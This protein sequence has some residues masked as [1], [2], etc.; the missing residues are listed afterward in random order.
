MLGSENVLRDV[1]GGWWVALV[2][3]LIGWSRVKRR[4]ATHTTRV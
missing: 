3:E 1:G 4:H 2:V